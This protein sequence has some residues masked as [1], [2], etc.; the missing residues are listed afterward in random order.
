MSSVASSAVVAGNLSATLL[1]LGVVAIAISHA[2]RGLSLSDPEH[3]QVHITSVACRVGP[4]RCDARCELGVRQSVNK[5]VGAQ[6]ELV[7]EVLPTCCDRV[8]DMLV[9]RKGEAGAFE[10]RVAARQFGFDYRN[11]GTNRALR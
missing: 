6:G 8:P 7:R 5:G 2:P 1:R 9:G 3:E 4:Q 11:T 10:Q